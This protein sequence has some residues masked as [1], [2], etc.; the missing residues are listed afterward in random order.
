[1]VDL[2]RRNSLAALLS[3]SAAGAVPAAKREQTGAPVLSISDL[4]AVGDGRADDTEAFRAALDRGAHVLVPPAP[5]HYRITRTLALRRPGQRV[6][7]FG[8]L[9]R[10]VLDPADSAQGN[11][12]VTQHEDSAFVGLHL[13]PA[14]NISSLFNGWAIA[15]VET[16]RVLVHD[17]HFSGM[18]RGGVLLSDSNDCRVCD[19]VFVASVIKGD[20]SERQAMTGYD[21][22]V[23]GSSSRAIVSG[24]QCL[25][26]VGT[27]IGCQTV[28]PGKSQR[29]NTIANNVIA[30]YP[31]YGIMVYLSDPSDRIEGVTIDGNSIEGISG[32]IRTDDK[33]T[34]YGC[35][36]YLQSANDMIVT[37]NRI[38][39]TNRDQ[40]RPFSGSAVPAAIGISGYGNAVVAENVIDT[41]HHGIASIQ[42]TAPPRRGDGTII[43]DNLVRNCEGAGIWLADN[44][45]ATVHD[46]RLTAAPGKG[47]HGILAHRFDSNWMDG[48]LIRGN[49]ITDFAV[50]V[51]VS[52]EK[53]PRAEISSNHIRGNQGNAI[54]SS[55][56]TTM[57]HHNTIEGRFGVSLARAAVH[58]TC[59]DNIIRTSALAIIDDGGSGIRVEDNILPAGETF[60]T[61]I[62]E[63]LS[64]GPA[65]ALSGKQWFRKRE[66]SAIV[67]LAGGYEGQRISIIAEA[68]FAIRHGEAIQLHGGADAQVGKGAVVSLVLIEKA[69]RQTG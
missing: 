69:W 42:V 3:V 37:R 19:N 8:A 25:S 41:C 31:G 18:R 60:S 54:Y 59:R 39:A 40:R 22:L 61:S 12:F 34:F 1:M 2:A 65:P 30:G 16:Q 24:N 4:G 28:T 44:I 29:G 13:V 32:S 66:S 7:G 17:C 23:A 51:E 27:A 33:T 35:G 6:F 63:A 5:R 15:A 21:V 58:G 45:A 47:T 53:V 67:N 10:I 56:A 14:T 38:L 46:N 43:A 57:I 64:P 11:L 52:G 49:E 55:A 50:G 48:F 9:S 20:G 36:I 68:P 26:G 62:A